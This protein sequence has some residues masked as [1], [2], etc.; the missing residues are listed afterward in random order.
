MLNVYF[1][2]PNNIK[3]TTDIEERFKGEV[4]ERTPLIEALM[5]EIEGASYNDPISFIDRFGYKLTTREL[6][7]GC[8]AAI[9]VAT[10]PDEVFDLLECGNNARDSILRHCKDGN[11]IVRDN[12][13]DFG[14]MPNVLVA[15]YPDEVFDLLECGNNARDSILRH[16]KDGNVIVRDNGY[17]FG[18]MPN[19]VW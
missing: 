7:T 5:R 2:A 11:V 19:G 14:V 13:Y 1:D 12:G 16:C 10:Y 9:L 4:V 3:V 15:T 17:D 18:V 8:K 6:S